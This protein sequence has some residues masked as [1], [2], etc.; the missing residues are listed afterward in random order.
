MPFGILND[1]IY[2]KHL[3]NLYNVLYWVSKPNSD[4]RNRY[5]QIS[6]IDGRAQQLTNIPQTLD[7]GRQG[8]QFTAASFIDALQRNKIRISMN[9]RGA[10]RDNVFV[11]RL[12]KSVKYEEV[13]LHA[14]TPSRRPR[15]ASNAI[16]PFTTTG[17][18]IR[19]LTDRR[20]ITFT[21]TLSRSRR[22]RNPRSSTYPDREICLNL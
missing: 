7:R 17:V 15:P 14:Y 6:S 2:N 12:W 8:S 13:Y 4:N 10:W 3:R 1:I 16:F 19:H 11:E 20:L 18:R 5:R 22:L 21:S 9:G